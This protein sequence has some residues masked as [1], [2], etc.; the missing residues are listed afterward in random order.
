MGNQDPRADYCACEF[1]YYGT[2]CEHNEHELLKSAKLEAQEQWNYGNFMLFQSMFLCI[3]VILF[4]IW[5]KRR[6]RPTNFPVKTR[7]FQ[8]GYQFQQGIRGLSLSHLFQSTIGAA[9][10]D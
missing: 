4:Y 2:H 3:Q 7:Y 5:Y 9:R 1:P 10:N 8:H 6:E